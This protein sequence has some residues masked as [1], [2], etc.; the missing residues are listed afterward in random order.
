[1]KR[2][3]TRDKEDICYQLQGILR[4]SQV[5]DVACD[6]QRMIVYA[7]VEYRNGGSYLPDG[8]I[9]GL[10]AQIYKAD[11]GEKGFWNYNYVVTSDE[12]PAES[13]GIAHMERYCHC[14]VRI[15]KRLS[16]P[17]NEWAQEWRDKCRQNAK[18]K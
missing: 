13:Y 7:A 4:P 11:G 5:V 8:H 12:M 10:A 16:P 15:L 6:A 9:Y 18:R 2:L 14:P 17:K 3:S 1:M